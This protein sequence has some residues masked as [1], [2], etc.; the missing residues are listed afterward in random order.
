MD[1]TQCYH[2]PDWDEQV[3][4]IGE[5]VC[6]SKSLKDHL[7]TP[8]IWFAL[9]MVTAA[10]FWSLSCSLMITA[11]SFSSMT[12]ATGAPRREYLCWGFLVP[13]WGILHFFRL[14]G[15]SHVQDHLARTSRSALIWLGTSSPACPWLSYSFTSSTK[16]WHVTWRSYADHSQKNDEGCT[17]DGTLCDATSDWGGFIQISPHLSQPADFAQ[18]QG[19]DPLQEIPSNL[20]VM[21]LWDQMLVRNR[22]KRLSKVKVGYIDHFLVFHKLGQVFE[23]WQKLCGTRS[24]GKEAIL[25]IIQLSCFSKVF[26]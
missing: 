9:L 11:R 26:H 8:R 23:W 24:L 5:V 20:N 15:N 17:K 22:I 13:R 6:V 4:L 21:E 16:N 19:L 12:L 3:Y 2:A 18:R 10:C 1:P 14:K 25:G 7:M